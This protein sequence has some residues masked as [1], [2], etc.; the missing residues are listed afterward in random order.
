HPPLG[1]LERA[2]RQPVL[3]A[4]KEGAISL[5]LGARSGGISSQSCLRHKIDEL[6]VGLV[7]PLESCAYLRNSF[8]DREP[9]HRIQW[10]RTTQDIKCIEIVLIG[11]IDPAH[12]ANSCVIIGHGIAKSTIEESN[13]TIGQ[14]ALPRIARVVLDRPAKH[15]VE[16]DSGRIASVL[17][18]DR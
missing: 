4:E 11:S 14:C 7:E 8:G 6:T 9:D 16:H 12:L 10:L 18:K 3:P 15:K 17:M 2:Q 13:R 5:G 1:L